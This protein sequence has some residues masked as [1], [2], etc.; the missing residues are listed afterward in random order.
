LT[1]GQL[2][3]TLPAVAW[4]LPFWALYRLARRDPAL[5]QV[6]PLADGPLVSVIIPARNESTNL[7]AIVASILPSSYPAFEIIL[8]DDRS[9]DDTGAIADGL[10]ADPRVRVVHG[11]DLPAGW[12]G[13]PWACVQ[14]ARAARGELLLFTDADTRHQ[15]ALI[16]HAA[17]ALQREGG[18]LTLAPKQRCGTFWEWLIMPQFWF[19]LGLRYHPDRVNRATRR[20]DIIANGQFIMVTRTAYDAV[21]THEAVRTEVAEDVALA[22][23]FLGGGHAVKLYFAEPLIETRMYTSLPEIVEGW[24]KNLYL[25][26]R[27]SF[28]DEPLLR[29]L[30]PLML[31]GAFAFWLLPV[32]VLLLAMV[33]PLATGLVWG[34]AM[35]V[36][37]SLGFWTMTS[38]GMRCPTWA[39]LLYPL[40]AAMA[41][42]IAA[43]STWRG[44]RRVEWRGRVYST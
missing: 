9:T 32:L 36:V 40:G 10:A 22:Q 2:G 34:A 41:M 13:K 6:P 21:G 5:E 15:P 30:S 31:A 19:L 20:R 42:Y 16:A 24:S 44:S 18:M 39:G 1:F 43:R 29:W 7:A 35:A 3:L 37:L 33:T 27:R 28:P 17:A 8:V 25:G 23:A 14:G 11:T 4:A 38:F 26:S 12:Y